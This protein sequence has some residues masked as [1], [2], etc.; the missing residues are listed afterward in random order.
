MSC[1]VIRGQSFQLHGEHPEG[2]NGANEGGSAFESEQEALAGFSVPPSHIGIFVRMLNA[3]MCCPYRAGMNLGSVY[4]GAAALCPELSYYRAGMG[5]RDYPLAGAK[6][7]FRFRTSPPSFSTLRRLPN[8][9][10]C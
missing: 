10:I 5:L 9:G 4:Q 6:Q 2:E 8:N 1:A 3:K 7:I